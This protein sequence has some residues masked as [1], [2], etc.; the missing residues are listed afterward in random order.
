MKTQIPTDDSVV[1]SDELDV[2]LFWH[3][4]KKN[5]LLGAFAVLVIGGGSLAWF[6]QSTLTSQ[7]AVTAL[8]NASEVPALEAVISNYGGTMPGADALLLVAAARQKEGKYEEST[9][10]FQSF[11]K[12]HPTHPLAGGALL[13]VGQNQDAAGKAAEAMATYQQVVEKYPKSYAAPFAGY[14]HAEILLRDF[15]RDEAKVVLNSLISQFPDSTVTRLAAAQLARIA[16]RN[17]K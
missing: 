3:T 6:V 8:A 7:A 12:S 13:G 11:L 5:I 9:A 2:L 10:A 15:K 17:S 1:E 4:H 14:A 16:T